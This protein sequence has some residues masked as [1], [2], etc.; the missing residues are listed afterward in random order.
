MVEVLNPPKGR[1]NTELRTHLDFV[2]PSLK[3]RLS[4]DSLN[5]PEKR[6]K[7]DN[8]FD[9]SWI[10]S[11]RDIRRIRAELVEARSTSA[12]LENRIQH[13]HV[14]R[15]ELQLM[16]DNEIN[17]YQQQHGRD[18]ESIKT[19]EEQLQSARKREKEATEA[20]DTIKNTD[21]T[22]K[23]DYERK[24]E[25][26]ELDNVRM[27]SKL[28]MFESDMDSE[29]T[30]QNNKIEELQMVLEAAREDARAH[31][32]LTKELETRVSKLS[33]IEREIEM[34]EQALLKAELKVKD[35]EYTLES[36]GEWQAQSKVCIQIIIPMLQFQS[37][38]PRRFNNIDYPH[39]LSWRRRCSVCE[40]RTKIFEMK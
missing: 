7:L 40:T 16:F 35:L 34:K 10:P 29:V 12:S 33:A 20:L 21:Y 36:Y 31:K 13:M 2:S 26:L 23:L 25:Q 17:S 3:R 38:F 39:I 5:P 9:S 15:K 18:R 6:E 4:S 24:I 19:L 1:R 22:Q 14:I 8:S 37:D 27:E 30:K 32:E 11:P 28:K